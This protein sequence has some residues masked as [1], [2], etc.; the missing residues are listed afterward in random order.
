MALR[1]STAACMAS[2]GVVEE[3]AFLIAVQHLLST[4]CRPLLCW[5]RRGQPRGKGSPGPAGWCG[6]GGGLT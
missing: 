6:V 3:T 2:P 4:D 1:G 5:G